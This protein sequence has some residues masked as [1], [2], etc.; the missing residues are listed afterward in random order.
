MLR[1]VTFMLC[2]A[3]CVLVMLRLCYV[4][5]RGIT[6]HGDVGAT[7]PQRKIAQHNVS[8]HVQKPY[9]T[10][11]HVL[12]RCNK[13]VMQNVTERTVRFDTLRCALLRCTHVVLRSITFLS[14]CCHVVVRCGEKAAKVKHVQ[15]EHFQF[16]CCD[17]WSRFSHVVLGLITL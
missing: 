7:R 1:F 11:C 15:H 13:V 9:G 16:M 10:L 6:R 12:I 14:R 2:Y 5:W 17:V 3:T 4:S 8:Q